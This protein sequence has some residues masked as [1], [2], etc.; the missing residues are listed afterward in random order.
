[1]P[2]PVIPETLLPQFAATN[3]HTQV[4]VEAF[5]RIAWAA[6][7]GGIIGLERQ[8][9]QKSAGLRTHMLVA[10][11]AA[12][13]MIISLHPLL[14]L[15][16]VYGGED[17]RGDVF[18][19]DPARIAAQIVT[20]IGFIGGGAVLRSGNSIRGVTTAA[21][22]WLMGGVGMLAGNGE[23]LLSL[24]IA[25]LGLLILRGIGTLEQRFNLKSSA[26]GMVQELVV[27]IPELNHKEFQEWFETAFSDFILEKSASWEVAG[28]EEA[29]GEENVA[30][31]EYRYIVH[32]PVQKNLAIS[33]W[34][35]QFTAYPQIRHLSIKWVETQE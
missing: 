18:Q 22:L 5:C 30:H 15:E 28:S 23:F 1:M 4:A 11:G 6:L 34:R 21:S 19:Q 17:T 31:V 29:G 35:E 14:P 8:I 27:V 20:G 33:Y 12:V 2:S 24:C 26:S 10:M 9:T 25:L 7:L 32:P 3:L 16:S 13:F